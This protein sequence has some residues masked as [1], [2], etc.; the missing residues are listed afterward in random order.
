MKILVFSDSHN[1][2]YRIEHAL[3]DNKDSELLIHLGDGISDL[4][5]IRA[6][7][8]HYKYEYILGNN[9]YSTDVPT[10]KILEVEGKKLFILHGHE[11]ARNQTKLIKKAIFYK[12]DIVLSGH[13]HKPHEV[14]HKGI[15]F[16][17]PGCVS[18]PKQKDNKS[19]LIININEG[20]VQYSFI[21]I[22][23]VCYFH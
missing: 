3:L 5:S 20:K 17:N 9:D 11:Y 23:W 18:R 6:A 7:Y 16:L 13:T 2:A 19:Y 21:K 1:N 22:N 14:T 12:A 15:L 10:E 4:M 8:P